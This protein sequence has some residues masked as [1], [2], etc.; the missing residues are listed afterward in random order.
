MSIRYLGMKQLP[1]L[2][3]LKRALDAFVSRLGLR[4]SGLSDKLLQRLSHLF[5]SHLPA[6][7]MMWRD[8]SE[9]H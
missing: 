9:H 3:R 1:S 5:P 2:F 6:R 8:R 4:G 7:M